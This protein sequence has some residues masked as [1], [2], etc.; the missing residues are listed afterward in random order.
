[1]ICRGKERITKDMTRIPSPE[2]AKTLTLQYFL[3]H[4]KIWFGKNP[5][6][7][8][9]VWNK[10]EISPGALHIEDGIGTVSTCYLLMRSGL[11]YEGEPIHVANSFASRSPNGGTGDDGCLAESLVVV[12]STDQ[13][14]YNMLGDRRDIYHGCMLHPDGRLE[15]ESNFDSGAAVIAF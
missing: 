9:N 3:D 14:Q 7:M 1:M 11:T 13:V 10:T 6:D 12:A 15:W 2:E 5:N 4:F 8:L